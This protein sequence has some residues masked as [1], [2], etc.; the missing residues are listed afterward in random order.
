M[1]VGRILGQNWQ[2][3]EDL[4]R[5]LEE[6]HTPASDDNFS[7]LI[8]LANFL[9]N[10]IFPFPQQATYP[11]VDLLRDDYAAATDREDA[12]EAAQKFIPANLLQQLKLEI[13]DLIAAGR[14]L[15]PTVRQLVVNIQKSICNRS[16]FSI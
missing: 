4:C 14:I 10:G 7:R 9:A 12:L 13:A 16:Q 5:L 6:H 8:A 2:F 1:M 15:T 3:E 11:M